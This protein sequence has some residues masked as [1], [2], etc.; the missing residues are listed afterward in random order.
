MAA[1][2]NR[3][4]ILGST[5]E[6]YGKSDDLP[7]NENGDLVLGPPYKGRWS[8][9]CS[10]AIDEFLALAY[11]R[12]KGLPVV[13]ARMFNIVGPRQTGAYGMVLP[14]FIG[15]ALSG[16][17]IT[18]Y[19]DGEQ[20]RSFTWVGD[21]VDALIKLAHCPRAVG[22]IFNIGSQNET[23]INDL[24]ALVKKIT[25]SKSEIVHIP[26]DEAYEQGFEDLMRRV[27]DTSKLRDFIGYE[28]TMGIREIIETM[29]RVE[30]AVA[31]VA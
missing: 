28:P 18:V 10:K 19:G 8:Y 4:V 2:K 21:A 17:A 12:E 9:A 11:W 22:E 29:L 20:T 5:S 27:P 24:A 16:E 7:F 3:K 26:Y 14:S 30:E 1:K 31:A 23:S 25:E 13:I 6:V 15:Q